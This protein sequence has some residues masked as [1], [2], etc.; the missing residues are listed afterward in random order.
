MIIPTLVL[1]TALQFGDP[2]SGAKIDDLSHSPWQNVPTTTLVA[3]TEQTTGT[4]TGTNTGTASQFT[5][6]QPALST[7]T[8]PATTS[9]PPAFGANVPVFGLGVS[10]P[11]LVDGGVPAIELPGT[12]PAPTPSVVGNEPAQTF[13]PTTQP[14]TVMATQNGGSNRSYSGPYT[15]PGYGAR[16]E[17]GSGDSTKIS[18]GKV[19]ISRAK[20]EYDKVA[21]L[22]APV[23]GIVQE[24][25]TVK[26]DVQGNVTR[27]SNGE[28][29]KIDLN[30][31]VL[32]FTGQQIAQLDDRY[33]RAQYE[34]AVTKLRVA[35][36]DAEKDIEI[37]Y[38]KS[39]WDVAERDL[40]R[41]ED[42]NTRSPGA[43]SLSEIDVSRLSV[44]QAGLQHEKAIS[45]H[46]TKQDSVL[47]QKEEV[48]VAETQLDLRKIKTP[49]NAMVINV[50]TQ[51]GNY[52]KE[53]DPLA[54]VVQLDKLKVIANVDGNLITQEKVAGKRVTVTTVHDGQKEEFE[55][56]VR[57]AAPN[58]NSLRQFEIEIEVD[59][60]LVNDSWL[61]KQGDYVDVVIHL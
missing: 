54:E 36:K 29:I 33:A 61:L 13:A 25:R 5:V 38:A 2:Q 8:P 15:S 7:T 42:V 34:V 9:T 41:K 24:L 44:I 22:S 11:D 49:F 31:G 39:G 37:R 35:E 3:Y 45:D 48:R 57:Y 56:F 21:K 53:G 52:L 18:D 30:R 27:A 12:I 51:V 59:N 14:T 4:P 55:G 40:K 1:M 6:S 23:G 47:V 16:S 32:L 43:I 58:F 28:P 60:R 19:H 20:V 10:D 26:C 50:V 46:E 17:G